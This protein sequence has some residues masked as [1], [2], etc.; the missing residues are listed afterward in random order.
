MASSRT[1]AG[2]SFDSTPL[3]LSTQAIH[4]GNGVDAETGAIR[5]PI[6]LANSYDLPYDPSDINWSSSDVNI[7]T[8]NGHP[9]QHY[10]EQ[11]L[12]VL[13]SPT[14]ALGTVGSSTLENTSEEKENDLSHSIDTVVLASGVAALSATFTTF[15]SH[16]DH[17][18]FSDTTYVGAY[19]Q[20]HEILPDKYGIKTS[21]VD[22]SNLE[23][24]AAAIQPNTKLIHIETPANPTL[25]VSDIAAI[26]RIA[27]EHGIL[28]SV[29]NTFNTPINVKPLAWGA[30]LVIES[31]TKYI[32]GHGD[33]LGG[34]I[35][36]RKELTDRI[37]SIY[38]VNY[39]GIISPFN[40]WLINRGSVTL[41]LRM[42]QHNDSTLAIAKHLSALPQVSFVAYPGLETHRHHDV[43]VSQL[44][45]PQS[46][47]GG[48]LSFGL[49]TDH[50]G[51]NRF[52]SKLE[53]ITS[54]VSLGH[55]ESLIVFLGEDDERQYIYSDEF[56]H[57]FFRLAIGLENTEDLIRDI[58][59]ALA[60]AE[61]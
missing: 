24:L 61:I 9:N 14:G 31:L 55:D 38:Q 7:Y 36:G 13:E 54:A 60:A 40:S 22:S 6:T 26:A 53:V 23:A 59:H 32:N 16:G 57:G 49:K 42:K 33:A 47:F 11:K 28:L 19:R 5:R 27:H 51:H 1:H 34:S 21:M 17:A 44:A 30:D 25:K 52:V 29:D 12:S 41:P 35:S 39:G 50:D 10:L 3:G 37:R 58:D 15:L 2:A 48:V 45:G 20:L 46:G 56:H 4:V 43:A 18:V 8:R